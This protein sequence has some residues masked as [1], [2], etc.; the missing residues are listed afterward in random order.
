[1]IYMGLY[2]DFYIHFSGHV[3]EPATRRIPIISSRRQVDNTLSNTSYVL[4]YLS[5]VSLLLNQTTTNK[6]ERREYQL[7]YREKKDLE[8]II[9]T[10]RRIA[11]IIVQN[12]KIYR[13][14]FL[15]STKNV[16]TRNS[17]R[18]YIYTGKTADQG[19][20]HPK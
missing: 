6:K 16:D 14:L 1:M 11:G 10:H 13:H 18:H 8:T 2:V 3:F 17:Y 4:K 9:G 19:P 7:Y 20:A 12:Y 15:K 5:L